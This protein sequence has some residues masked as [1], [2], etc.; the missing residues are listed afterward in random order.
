MLFYLDEINREI[1]N[2]PEEFVERCEKSF[3]D[4]I[5]ALCDRITS[6]KGRMLVMLAGPSSSGKTTTAKLL[7]EGIRKREEVLW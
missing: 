6:E 3:K 5:E 2:S 7:A 1:K 4:K